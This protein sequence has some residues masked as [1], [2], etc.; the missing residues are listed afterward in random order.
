MWNGNT[1][2]KVGRSLQLT[3]QHTFNVA[4]ADVPGLRKRSGNLTY[5]FFFIPGAC[6]WVDVLYR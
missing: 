1:V 5:G 2:A 4:N 3:G 6:A